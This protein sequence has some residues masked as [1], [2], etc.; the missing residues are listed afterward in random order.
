MDSSSALPERLSPSRLSDYAQCPRL[1]FYK[2]IERRH[3]PATVAT[4]KGSLAHY[5]F[6]HIFDLERDER[7]A[8]NAVPY[9]REHWREL[10]VKDDY[11]EIMSLDDAVIENMLVEAEGL[12]R[13]WFSVERPHNFDPRG[14]EM[15]VRGEIEGCA[16]HGVIDRLDVVESSGGQRV[17]ISDYKTGK[18]PKTAYRSKA[19][20]AM[21]IYDGLLSQ[22]EELGADELRLVY[23]VNGKREDVLRQSVTPE[24]RAGIRENVG[25]L[26]RGISENAAR[27]EW[28][29]EPS[30]L[31][32]WCP[33]QS[34][35]PAHTVDVSG[36]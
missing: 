4:T 12:V 7:R 24:S 23:V 1:F 14:R 2:T 18:I 8:E 10:S 3:S 36:F 15:W 5:A 30:V 27:G 33:F 19:F 26:W 22:Q 6:E 13:N 29:P 28:R 35:C 16:L 17:Y 20:F 11:A 21:N 31:C 9:V 32:G 25:R 34:I